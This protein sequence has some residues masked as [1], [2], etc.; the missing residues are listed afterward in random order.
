MLNEPTNVKIEDSQFMI[1]MQ[2]PGQ[3]VSLIKLIIK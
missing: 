2:L 3:A 1:E